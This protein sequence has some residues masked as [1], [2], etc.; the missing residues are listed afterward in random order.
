MYGRCECTRGSHGLLVLR[1]FGG[2]K[3]FTIL[4]T[5]QSAFTGFYKDVNT[6]LTEVSDR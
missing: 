1:V 4:K 2:I 5:T 3:G 6:T